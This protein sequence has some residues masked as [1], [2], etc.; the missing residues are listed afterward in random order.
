MAGHSLHTCWRQRDG[1]DAGAR[2]ARSTSA[3]ACRPVSGSG[4]RLAG[5]SGRVAGAAHPALDRAAGH[6]TWQR[7]GRGPVGCVGVS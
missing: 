1:Q 7:P 6:G 5:P 2:Q 4:L 3:A